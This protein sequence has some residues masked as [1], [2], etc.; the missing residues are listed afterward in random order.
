MHIK[1][2]KLVCKSDSPD[3]D[4]DSPITKAWVAERE[5]EMKSPEFVDPTTGEKKKPA[6]K[7]KAAPKKK[8][9]TPKAKSST[10]KA[11]P[12]KPAAKTDSDDDDEKDLAETVADAIA[13]KKITEAETAKVLLSLKQLELQKK[14]GEVMPIDMVQS[15]LAI[16]IKSILDGCLQAH[17]SL[18]KT[19][20]R[21]FGLGDREIEAQIVSKMH[22]KVEEIVK[23]ADETA[24][25]EI[26]ALIV[27]YSDKRNVGE[28][29]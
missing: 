3:I 2:G 8:P 21:M 4:M 17:D 22:E 5:L 1:R 24:K 7:A 20:C 29:K 9:S 14:R 11:Q 16:N 15:I 25:A 19:Y 12:E 23:K 6:Q 27:E 18:A 28:R 10:P 26:D 13:E